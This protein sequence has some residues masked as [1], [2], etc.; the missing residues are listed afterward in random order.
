MTTEKKKK[1]IGDLKMSVS[2][3]DEIMR[4]ALGGEVPKPKAESS[5][6]KQAKRKSKAGR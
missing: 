4:Q 2:E 6:K 3:F 5:D 1:K